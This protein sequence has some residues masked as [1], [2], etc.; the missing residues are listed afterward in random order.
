MRILTSAAAASAVLA[1]LLAIPARADAPFRVI[2]HAS[3]TA[4]SLPK[5]EVS[6]MFLKKVT[7]WPG[8]AVVK[9]VELRAGSKVREAFCDAVHGRSSAAVGTYWTQV[10]FSGR[11]TPPIEKATDEEVVAYVR[12]NEGAIGVVSASASVSG[13]KVIEVR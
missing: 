9:P 8:G 7:R 12:G 3:N 2:V 11:G 5:I 10:I 1:L 13:V 4:S 6:Q